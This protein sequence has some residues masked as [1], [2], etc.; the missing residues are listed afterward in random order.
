MGDYNSNLCFH[1]L[2]E[3][4]YDYIRHEIILHRKTIRILTYNIF[5]RPPPVK[6]NESDWKDERLV[7]FI[8]LLDMFDIICLQEM[9]GSLNNR[10]QQ[11]IKYANKAGYFFYC[12]CPSPSFFSKYVAEGGLIIL[13][14]FPIVEKE[15]Y[16]FRYSILSDSLCQKG[17]LYAKIRIGNSYLCIFNTHLQASYFD[18]FGNQWDLSIK[19]RIDQTDELIHFVKEVMV[20]MFFHKG[21]LMLDKQKF[22]LLGDF[23]IDAHD[24]GEKRKVMLRLNFRK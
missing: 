15:F 4:N 6:N 18:G 14:R 7:D 13:S 3:L 23:N 24:Y 11:L 2:M 10:K 20:N 8:K 22:I 19:T 16:P 1:P 5:L 21:D 17:V 9:F 12:E